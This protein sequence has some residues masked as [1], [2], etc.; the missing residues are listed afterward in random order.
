[1]SA[2]PSTTPT[3]AFSFAACCGA[4]LA[5]HV[6]TT[7]SS[8]IRHS[9]HATYCNALLSVSRIL[10]CLRLKQRRALLSVRLELPH[11]DTHIKN[12]MPATHMEVLI[13]N[14]EMLVSSNLAHELLKK[15]IVFDLN[16]LHGLQNKAVLISQC[17]ACKGGEPTVVKKERFLGSLAKAAKPSSRVYLARLS[18]QYVS[19]NVR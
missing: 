14:N 12:I 6:V 15:H 11:Q 16:V 8:T 4:G 19:S 18:F 5:R 10:F 17:G 7:T 9:R 1:M 13:V 2:M 3:T